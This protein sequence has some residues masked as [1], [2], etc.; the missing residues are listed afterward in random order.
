M[1]DKIISFFWGNTTL[2]WLRYMTLYSF[3]KYNPEWT[4]N[5]YLSEQKINT[6]T[7]KTPESQDFFM[8]KGKDYSHLLKDIN[9]NIK[10]YDL[11]DRNGAEISPAQKSDFFEWHI[12]ATVGGFY[13]DMDIL[14]L[15]SIDN[16]Y[17]QTK[18]Y[19]TGITYTK[20]YSIGF[21]FSNGNN[22]FF[23]NVYDT[24]YNEF[25]STNYQGAGVLRLHKKWPNISVIEKN[26]GK[27]YN[28]PFDLF[29]QYDSNNV[30]KIHIPGD[31]YNLNKYCIGLHWYGGHRLS[32][33]A[34]GWFNE[35]NF[36]NK[37]NLVSRVLREVIDGKA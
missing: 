10:S 33:Q 13:S 31:T 26:Y 4:I 37:N 25:D 7:W 8:Y 11:K 20:Y 9:I 2:S 24:S 16:L 27:V 17:E 15:K 19:D 21:L 6:K 12:M 30:A 3:R 34:N 32:Q 14:F 22:E 29:Y 5:L 36:R 18:T 1:T 35:K 28:I 23:K